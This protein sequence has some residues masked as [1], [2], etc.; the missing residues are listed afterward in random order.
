M[1][2]SEWIP[3]S[4]KMPEPVAQIGGREFVSVIVNHGGLVAEGLYEPALD[5]PWIVFGVSTGGVTHWMPLPEPPEA[6]K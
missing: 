4:E 2:D 3:V 5:P 1:S 6:Q